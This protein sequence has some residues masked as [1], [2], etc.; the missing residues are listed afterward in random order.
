[1]SRQPSTFAMCPDCEEDVRISGKIDLGKSVV[2]PHCGADLEV[3][4][5]DPVEL[6]WSYEYSLNPDDDSY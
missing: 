6:S 3:V 5:L 1:M 2:C 4:D